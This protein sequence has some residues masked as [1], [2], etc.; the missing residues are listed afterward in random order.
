M[1]APIDPHLPS[2]IRAPCKL[3][4]FCGLQEAADG[5]VRVLIGN[6]VDLLEPSATDECEETVER[7][8]EERSMTATVTRFAE[9]VPTAAALQLAEVICF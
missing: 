6:K 4:R 2:F 1:L 3:A 5:A 8:D 9:R 7:P